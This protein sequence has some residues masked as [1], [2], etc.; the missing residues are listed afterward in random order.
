MVVDSS[1]IIAVL[2]REPEAFSIARALSKA[3]LRRISPV[4]ALETSMVMEARKGERGGEELDAFFARSEIEIF[5]M[6]AEQWEI[7]RSAWR[8]FGKGRHPAGL[9]MGDCCAYALAK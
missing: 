6:N 1:A 4:N 8:S 5:P 9:N 7:A 2:F 3:P